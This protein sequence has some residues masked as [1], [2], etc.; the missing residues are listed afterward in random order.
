MDST[1]F[2]S[3]RP[4]RPADPA[5]ASPPRAED[6]LGPVFDQMPVG[7]VAVRPDGLTALVNQWL[8]DFFDP[9]DVDEDTGVMRM[10]WTRVAHPDGRSVRP[11]TLPLERCMRDGRVVAS[12]E[13]VYHGVRGEKTISV[14]AFAVRGEN[15]AALAYV[16]TVIDL[17]QTRA[18]LDQLG[19]I[20]QEL[21]THVSELSRVHGLIERLSSRSDLSSLLAETVDVVAE[22]DGADAVLIFLAD[23]DSGE[24]KMVA[25][26][27][28]LEEHVERVHALDPQFL[29]TSQRAMLGLPTNIVDVSGE[30][31]LPEQ[32]REVALALGA[33]SL[34]SLPLRS[35]DGGV[36]GSVVSLFR[37]VR[38]PSPHTLQLIETCG[39]IIAQLIVNAR[40]RA[41]DRD[42]ASALQRSMMQARLPHVPGLEL[43]ACYRAGSTGMYAGGDWYQV[44]VLSDG[45]LSIVIGDVVGHGIEAVGTMGQMSSAVR[46]YTLPAEGNV[47]PGPLE[48]VDLLDHWCVATG[49]GESSTVCVAEIARAT[50]RCVLAGAGHPP[51]LLLGPQGPVYVHEEALGAPLGLLGLTG[52]AHALSIDLPP[53]SILLFYTDGLIERRGEDIDTGL[54]R[55]AAVAQRILEHSPEGELDAQCERIVA[56]AAPA[57]ITTDD[58][59]LLILRVRG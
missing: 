9:F 21:D 3:T 34:H 30:P 23:S 19:E 49:L 18:F 45:R 44:S 29:Y 41:R 47:P 52:E 7:V 35:A 56:E 17:T 2:P 12:E 13:Y 51:P 24:L 14:D 59:A 16:S 33:V 32:Y 22:L 53:G 25:S 57:D 20:Q 6:L 48:I 46:A 27:G 5:A 42:V 1:D 58:A 15:G 39:R 28:L 50:G 37:R 40:I 36:L 43:A 4:A 54:A 8:I 38:M 26:H 55:L 31:G 11:G 10:D